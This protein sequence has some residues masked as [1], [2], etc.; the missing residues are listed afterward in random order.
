VI[1]NRKLYEVSPSGIQWHVT[2]EHQVLSTHHLKP[3]A[4]EAGVQAARDNAPSS[5]LIKRADGTVEDERTYLLDPF[6][7]RG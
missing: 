1:A 7:P 6:P 5:L 3:R 2:H 4:V